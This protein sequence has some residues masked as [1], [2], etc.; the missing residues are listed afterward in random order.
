[1]KALSIARIGVVT[2]KHRTNRQNNEN[3]KS[4]FITKINE[5]KSDLQCFRVAVSRMKLDSM[6]YREK[7]G[8]SSFCL[9]KISTVSRLMRFENV[10]TSDENEGIFQQ[11]NF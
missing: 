4:H 9:S 2:H 11:D 6:R 7:R 8:M 3:G 10:A 5:Q 1:M